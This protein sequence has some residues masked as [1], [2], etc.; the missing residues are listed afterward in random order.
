MASAGATDAASTSLLVESRFGN[1]GGLGQ[2]IS[3]DSSA[4]AA[5]VQIHAGVFSRS[6]EKVQDLWTQRMLDLDGFGRNTERSVEPHHHRLVNPSATANTFAVLRDGSKTSASTTSASTPSLPFFGGKIQRS[7]SSRPAASLSARPAYDG[8]VL[9]SVRR[10]IEA[11]EEKIGHQIS[12]LR[13]QQQHDRLRDAA[14]SRFEEKLNAIESLQ[15]RQDQRMAEITGHFKGLSDEMQ[16]QIRRMDVMDERL[17]EWRRQTEED[18]RQRHVHLEQLVQRIGSGARLTGASSEE[19]HQRLSQRVHKI[20]ADV[21]ERLVLQ[22]EI[23]QSLTSAWE[24]LQAI[25]SQSWRDSKAVPETS[26]CTFKS[27]C[28]LPADEST[29]AT[30]LVLFQQTLKDVVSKVE[31]IFQDVRDVHATLS[32]QEE[33]QKTLRTLMNAS[34]ENFRSLSN[35]VERGD[36]DRRLEQLQQAIQEGAS[37]K[38]AHMERMELMAKRIEYQEQAHDELCSSHWQLMQ[39]VKTAGDLG[40]QTPQD[41]KVM[42]EHTNNTSEIAAALEACQVR[43]AK[44]ENGVS[45]LVL[46]LKEVMPK[47]VE[48]QAAIQSLQ[49]LNSNAEVHEQMVRMEDRMCQLADRIPTLTGIA[50]SAWEP[51]PDATKGCPNVACH[52]VSGLASCADLR[53]EMLEAS[54]ERIKPL[55]DGLE[56]LAAQIT[57]NQR[58]TRGIMVDVEKL[59]FDMQVKIKRTVSFEDTGL[60]PILRPAPPLDERYPSS[61]VD[62]EFDEHDDVAG[63][64]VQVCQQLREA[65]ASSSELVTRAVLEDM[66]KVVRQDVSQLVEDARESDTEQVR[67]LTE[68]ARNCQERSETAFNEIKS[69]AAMVKGLVKGGQ[70]APRGSIC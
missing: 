16:A 14:F 54:L 25:E 50:N 63:S 56:R 62:D 47:V 53:N 23:C 21:Q 26:V 37:Q 52:Q 32:T 64:L 48:Q 51:T 44:T 5:P 27:A 20:E 65:T 30:Q 60:Q 61:N 10:Q 67:N 15:P 45:A 41:Y 2:P 11:F 33:Q 6:G 19:N 12:H 24:R 3:P 29:A 69:I 43:M 31:G 22:E 55:I 36:W 13:C 8:A 58:A 1:W 9:T 46:A 42:S 4:E 34:E 49:N 35:R 38:M 59:K 68:L 39:N 57:V 17:S 66:V 18:L 28:S 7:V 70:P 40:K